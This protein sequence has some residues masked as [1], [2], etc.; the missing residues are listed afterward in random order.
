MRGEH[1]AGPERSNRVRDVQLRG[2]DRLAVLIRICECSGAR[3]GLGASRH[4]PI[5]AGALNHCG[6][7][8]SSATAILFGEQTF[9]VLGS[10]NGHCGRTGV[11]YGEVYRAG[12][13]PDASMRRAA[14]FYVRNNRRRMGDERRRR[15]IPSGIDALRAAAAAR[16]QTG[17]YRE[18]EIRFE[19]QIA[20]LK[21]SQQW[22]ES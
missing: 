14:A 21:A 6:D 16:E 12:R 4:D 13:N 15:R 19:H 8:R 3:A 17:C 20:L 11:R 2:S 10:A 7:P 5:V 9:L 18:R 22:R 1:D